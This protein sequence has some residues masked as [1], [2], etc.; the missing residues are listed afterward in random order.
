[1]PIRSTPRGD[2]SRTGR[3]GCSATHL[4][5]EA[6]ALTVIEEHELLGLAGPYDVSI[7]AKA[8]FQPDQ[9]HME[10]ENTYST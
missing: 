2:V 7:V 10:R 3:C 5:R 1:M 8:P 9:G 6:I 4:V